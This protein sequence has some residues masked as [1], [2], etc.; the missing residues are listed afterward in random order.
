LTARLLIVALDG[1]DSARL[2]RWSD[3]GLLPNLAALRRR[4]VTRHLDNAQGASDDSLWASFQYGVGEPW[5]GR[6][7]YNHAAPTGEA[8]FV[9]AELAPYE[10]FWRRLA[11]RGQRVAVFD[12]P[13]CAA[14]TA[15]N[16]VH[17]TD[18]L[19]HGRY[20]RSALSY[21]PTLAA[22]VL[23]RFGPPPPSRCGYFAPALS[24]AEVEQVVENLGRSTAMKL[25]AARHYLASEAWD[26]FAVAFKEGH[27]AG[28][29]LL[30]FDDPGHPEW[31]AARAERLGWPL[32]RVFQSLDLALGE[33]LA[34]IGESTE[35][36]VVSTTGMQPNG[37]AEHLAQQIIARLNAVVGGRPMSWPRQ[38]YGRLLA[39]APHRLSAKLQ[40]GA[41]RLGL[42]GEPPGAL[43]LAHVSDNALALNLTGEAP[44]EPDAR[45]RLTDRVDAILATLVD[46]DSG[47][48][49]VSAV[50]H[51]S[52]EGA[53]PC[54][55]ALP[56]ILA[57]FRP[58]VIPRA[59]AATGLG[60]IRGR[61]D[62][63]RPGNHAPGGLA[64]FAGPAATALG[65]SVSRLEDFAA[66]AGGVLGADD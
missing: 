38:L 19:V 15:L 13:K 34:G 7:F 46:V 24:D 6:T 35:V 31:D 2:R 59:V 28:H 44:A 4:G 40:R 3:E 57:H 9:G 21:P 26:L 56:D 37:S 1:A 30:N 43:A 27:C 11:D 32:R 18:W 20:A 54:A 5:H 51:P 53:G 23:A 10:P 48:G 29:G 14:P 16:G 50:T 66:F 41:R 49:L 62:R 55:A 17:L 12:I 45:A 33:L 64:V 39:E 52:R 25:A 22:E 42:P 61:R 8:T 47:Q 36:A 60:V 65:A 63:R 58:G